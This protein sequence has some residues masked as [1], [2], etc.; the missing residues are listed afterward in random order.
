MFKEKGYEEFLA[1]CIQRGN[2][3]I[4]AGRVQSLEL[5]KLKWQQAI[6]RKVLELAEL[7]E[8]QHEVIYG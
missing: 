5:A 1:D 8:A 3:D 7:E 2:A 6:E 4:E